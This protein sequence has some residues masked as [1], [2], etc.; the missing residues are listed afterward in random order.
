MVMLL[1]FIQKCLN[2][3]QKKIINV[4]FVFLNMFIVRVVFIKYKKYLTTYKIVVT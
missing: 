1:L 4:F 2:F 3:I